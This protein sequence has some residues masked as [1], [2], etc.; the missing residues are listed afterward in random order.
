MLRDV[1]K[2]VLREQYAY[3]I[4]K[5]EEKREINDSYVCIQF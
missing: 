2:S 1:F 3:N 4:Q 5:I